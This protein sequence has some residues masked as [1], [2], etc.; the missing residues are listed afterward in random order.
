MFKRLGRVALRRLS[1]LAALV[2]ALSLPLPAAAETPR[3]WTNEELGMGLAALAVTTM[4]WAQT[5]HISAYPQVW[6]E[7]NPLLGKHPDA[8]RVN[9]HF[10]IGILAGAALAH[11]FPQYRMAGLKTVFV[12][13]AFV[14]GRN[15]YL[16]V[17]MDW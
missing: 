4:D 7:L 17:R 9:R 3:P 14:V 2:A 10:G 13:E 11:Y 8:A 16:G 5:R 15:A 1:G 6:T 12:L